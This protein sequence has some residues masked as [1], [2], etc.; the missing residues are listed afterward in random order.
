MKIVVTGGAGFIGSHIT[1]AYVAEGHQVFIV[2]DLSSGDRRN[3]NPQADFHMMDLLDPALPSLLSKI[4]PDV[5]NHHAAQMDVRRSVED[6]LFDAR[7]NVLG[8]I[9]LLERCKRVG[10]KK[11]IYASSGG[12]IYGEQELFPTPEEHPKRPESPYGVSKLTGEYYLNYYQSAFGISPVSLRYGNVYGPRQRADGEAGV[13]AIFI[14][15]LLDNAA[16][17]INGDGKQTRDYVYVGDVVAANLRALEFSYTGAVN[18]GTGRETDVLELFRL[19][20]E[21]IGSKA[22]AVHAP[23]K[24]GEQRRSCLDIS[25]AQERL[26]WSPRTPLSEGLDSTIAYYRQSSIA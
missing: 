26:G 1:D 18:I 9:H 10:V 14:R 7:I 5:V 2:D 21:R 19:L 13:I 24:I 16:P 6:P 20:R 11:V 22:V 12:A 4:S 25:R 15:H 17:K 23:A 3:L 8:L